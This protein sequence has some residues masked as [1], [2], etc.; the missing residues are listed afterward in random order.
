MTLD[1]LQNFAR[2]FRGR[3]EHLH[4]FLKIEERRAERKAAEDRMAAADFWDN[5]EAA[6]STVATLSAC[7]AIIE[8]FEKMIQQLDD[9]EAGIELAAEDA[10]F[11]AES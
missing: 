3:L 11:M 10:V 5:K 4:G 9:F 8:P 6:Q 7:R 2:D 1:E